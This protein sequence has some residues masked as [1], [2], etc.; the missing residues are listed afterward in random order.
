MCVVD[1]ERELAKGELAKPKGMNRLWRMWL[2]MEHGSK[3][4]LVVLVH[5]TIMDGFSLAVW[6]NEIGYYANTII[7][8][9]STVR[10]DIRVAW[11]ILHSIFWTFPL[12]RYSLVPRTVILNLKLVLC[13]I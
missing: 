11:L 4:A 5:H 12:S 3:G 9:G 13:P 2:T 1:A 10:C 7:A 6:L 8:A